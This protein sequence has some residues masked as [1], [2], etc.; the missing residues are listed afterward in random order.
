MQ[1]VL[2]RQLRRDWLKACQSS[3]G[4]RLPA[5]AGA[6]CRVHPTASPAA[7]GFFPHSPDK[8]GEG[9]HIAN[10]HR[11]DRSRQHHK[12]HSGIGLSRQK[13]SK[14]TAQIIHPVHVHADGVAAC[15][16]GLK[17]GMLHR[18]RLQ[19]TPSGLPL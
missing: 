13:C 15:A 12:R 11:E 6:R 10:F 3:S 16:L 17:V 4:L 1:S 8:S 9:V 18:G 14:C 7:A 5:S 19:K 2:E